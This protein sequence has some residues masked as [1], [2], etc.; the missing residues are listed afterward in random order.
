MMAAL[1]AETPAVHEDRVVDTLA[2]IWV[3]S[4]YGEGR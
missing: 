2:H 1:S 4:I 3:T